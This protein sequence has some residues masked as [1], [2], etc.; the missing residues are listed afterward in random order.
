[1]VV[2]SSSYLAVLVVLNVVAFVVVLTV[3]ECLSVPVFQSVDVRV[4][5]W[6]RCACVLVFACP[7]FTL[8]A[9]PVLLFG[10]LTHNT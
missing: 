2:V 8:V 9:C 7:G 3:S 1:M 10:T 6:S 5:Q 4:D